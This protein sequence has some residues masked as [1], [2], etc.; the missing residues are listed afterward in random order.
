MQEF[1]QIVT[2]IGWPAGLVVFFVWLSWKREER[3][4]NRL[5]E[6]EN[7]V[8]DHQAAIVEESIRAQK[9]NTTALLTLSKSLNERPCLVGKFLKPDA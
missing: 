1:L 3:L 4:A 9:D 2:Q 8:R 6:V 5:D 7:Y